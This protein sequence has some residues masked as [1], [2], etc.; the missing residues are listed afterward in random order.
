MTSLEQLSGQQITAAALEADRSGMDG[1]ASWRSGRQP[2]Q[3]ATATAGARSATQPTVLVVDDEP[4]VLKVL[5]S[6]LRR[7][8]HCRVLEA[9]DAL[10]AQRQADKDPNIDLVIT[11]MTMPGASGLDLAAWF[12]AM[13]PHTKVLIASGSLWELN[14]QA[15]S[16]DQIAFLAKPFTTDELV[17][18]VRRVLR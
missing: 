18:M 17:R 14:Y 15:T 2:V 12:R 5:A 3:P 11:D 9:P 10:E 8:M 4:M 6:V 16:L 1:S 13:H 7:E